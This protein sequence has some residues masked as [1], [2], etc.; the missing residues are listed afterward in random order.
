MTVCIRI[1][2]RDPGVKLLLRCCLR[3][4]RVSLIGLDKG[5]ANVTTEQRR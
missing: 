4:G 5:A 3:W 2:L 1:N